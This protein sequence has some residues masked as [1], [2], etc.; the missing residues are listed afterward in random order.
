MEYFQPN[1]SDLRISRIG[2]GCAAISGH[3]YGKVE[4]SEAIGAIR[5]A[6]EGGVNLFDTAD[7]YGFGDTEKILADAL[8][9]ERH[10]AIITTKFGIN[11][12]E[13]AR[14]FRDCSVKRMTKALEDSLRRLR[15]DCIPIYL[16]HWY[17][18]VTPLCDLMAAL[19][20]C[21]KQG[22]I[23]Y[24][25]CS[26][27]SMEM[28]LEASIT[29]EMEVVQLPYNLVRQEYAT[30]LSESIEK[31]NML[32]MTYDVLARGL[33]TGKY[34][35]NTKFGDNDTRTRHQ[36][37][38]GP[39]LDSGLRIVRRIERIGRR[40]NKTPA[41]IAIKWA[42]GKSFINCVLIGNKRASQVDENTD[43]FKWSLTQEDQDEL[44]GYVS[45]MNLCYE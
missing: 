38:T 43:V 39:C 2:F 45:R 24:I 5:K 41:Q 18:G 14:T 3:D 34:N 19:Q 30:Q 4:K 33:L 42:L 16:V 12:D 31:Q 44:E 20:E 32:T 15:L 11:W 28:V 21:Q 36:Y 22:K 6:W 10:N 27:F 29:H 37:F 8:G 17:D 25:G 13:S 1:F 26:N 23:R 40:Y 7:V 9:S 35:K